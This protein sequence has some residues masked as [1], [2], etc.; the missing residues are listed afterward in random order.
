[1]D[2]NTL[3]DMINSLGATNDTSKFLEVIAATNQYIHEDQKLIATALL[4]A[5]KKI[6][7]PELRAEYQ[8]TVLECSFFGDLLHLE[9][10]THLNSG[11][12]RS[13]TVE[14]VRK[15]RYEYFPS[16]INTIFSNAL[17]KTSKK[18]KKPEVR[19]H[20]QCIIL[21]CFK[22][23]DYR[24][25]TPACKALIKTSRKI[26]VPEIR[27]RYQEKIAT[28]LEICADIQETS[29]QDLLETS[30]EIKDPEVRAKYQVFLVTRQFDSLAITRNFSL[31]NMAAI[32]LLKTLKEIKDPLVRVE[33]L[34]KSIQAGN[35]SLSSP[36]YNELCRALQESL[37]KIANPKARQKWQEAAAKCSLGEEFSRMVRQGLE[38]TTAAIN[39]TKTEPIEPLSN[40]EARKLS[41][42]EKK[43]LKKLFG[44][45]PTAIE[46]IQPP[47][48]A[49][50]VGVG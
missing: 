40:H 16:A 9:A 27:A 48:S 47:E 14:E 41:K 29:C 50:V 20:Y 46:A 24:I 5:S 8:K 35:S 38:A 30:D 4:K 1:M 25:L 21:N 43:R 22:K 36:I 11:N 32:A 13:Y 12:T 34:G 19:A 33:Y 18:I 42:D 28:F 39:A 17:L 7:S 44:T 23:A 6:K 49:S 31:K 10:C 15:F 45:L 2:E 26:K 37:S 3:I